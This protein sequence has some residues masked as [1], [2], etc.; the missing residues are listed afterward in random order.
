LT[1]EL[2]GL[3]ALLKDGKKTNKEPV[4][5]GNLG[6]GEEKNRTDCRVFDTGVEVAVGVAICDASIDGHR[7]GLIK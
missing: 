3:T 7:V 5:S 1:V 6:S 4:R 2:D